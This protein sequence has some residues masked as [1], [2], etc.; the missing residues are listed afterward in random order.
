[1]LYAGMNLFLDVDS[2]DF[3]PKSCQYKLNWDEAE[4]KGHMTM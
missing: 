1:M 4:A 2:N 3:I